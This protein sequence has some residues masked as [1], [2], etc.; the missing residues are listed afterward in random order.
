M[1]DVQRS[2]DQEFD[3]EDLDKDQEV[4]GSE[5]IVSFLEDMGTE[6]VFGYIGGAIMP[7]FD[8]LSNSDVR[9]VRTAHEQAA[10]HAADAYA[11]V[12]GK[13]GVCMSTSGPGATNLMTGLAN[14]YLDSSPVIALTGQVSTDLMGLDSFQEVDV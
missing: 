5:A 9:H 2:T 8:E 11:R 14:A 3:T 13:P 4:S 10:V 6:L 1:E 7:V 12:T